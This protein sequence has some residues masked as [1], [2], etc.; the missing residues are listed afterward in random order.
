MPL[1]ERCIDPGQGVPVI[2]ILPEELIDDR[3]VEVSGEFVGSE[4]LSPTT[5]T[6]A[7]MRLA[8]EGL[9]HKYRKRWLVGPAKKPARSSSGASCCEAPR[10]RHNHGGSGGHRWSEGRR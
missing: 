1:T 7:F 5:V 2:S 3:C 9:A 8:R 6:R 4:S 10:R